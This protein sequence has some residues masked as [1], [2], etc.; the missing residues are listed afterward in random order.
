[1]IVWHN[2]AIDFFLGPEANDAIDHL[3]K[4]HDASD[5]PCGDLGNAKSVLD[6]GQDCNL[7]FLVIRYR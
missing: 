6:N 1:M 3:K 7:H 2:V 5:C 4:H